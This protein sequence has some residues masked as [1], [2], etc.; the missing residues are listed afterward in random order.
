M[1]DKI[2]EKATKYSITKSSLEAENFIVK[3]LKTEGPST[4][5]C[6]KAE[7]AQLKFL[8]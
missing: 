7:I 2:L 3:M 5:P 4:F 8:D 1:E 6:K